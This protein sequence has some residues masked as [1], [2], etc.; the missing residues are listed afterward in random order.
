MAVNKNAL[1]RYKTID[2]C[3]QNNFRQ[4]TLNDLIEA[5][6]DALY[7]YEGKDV[8]VSKRTVQLDLQMMRSDKL[9]YNAPILVYDRKYYKYEDE[10]YSITKSPISNQDLIKL[11]EAVS[12]LKQFQGFSHFDE[13]GSM[14]QKLEDHVYTQKTH[15]K[16]LID[17]EKNDNLKGLEFLNELYQFILKKKTIE[18]TYKSFKARAENTFTFHPYLLKEF[19][20]RWFVIGKKNRNE[21]IMNLALDRIVSL[22]SSDASFVSEPNFNSETYYKNAIG[23]SVSPNLDTENVLLY[24]SHKHAPYVVTKPFHNSQKMIEKDNYG[25]TISLDVQLNFELEKEI[26][27]FGESIKV[28]AP[29]RLKRIIKER[30][31]DAVDFY[32]TEINEKSIRTVSKQLEHKGFAILSQLYSKRDIRKL[33]AKLDGY[34]K[35]NDEQPFGMREVLLKLP[36]LKSILFNKNFKKLTKAIGNNV[37]LTKAIYFDKS[38]QDN[39]YVTWHQDVPINVTRKIETEGFKSWTNKKGVIS[40]RPPEAISKNTFAMRIHLDDTNAEN[41]ALKVISGSH[42]KRLND[43]EVKLITESSIP[44]ICE[45]AL[46]GVQL[47]KPLL[48]HA[49]SKSMKQRRRRVLHLEFSSIE[50]PN[51]LKY[52]EREDL[53]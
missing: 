15:E 28:I 49:S 38:P 16:A 24:V 42:N 20:N 12:F 40:V 52:T 13:L 32:E 31:H 48:L 51:G 34:I 14:V 17:F 45:V 22:K 41:G 25:I 37:F 39:W 9:G 53:N 43:E 47:L 27:G 3:L 30:L 33:K 36:E 21:G 26:L 29:E 2:K 4:W 8:D 35:Q 11:S 44:F 1:I 10:N 5:V 50:L 7:E 23:V 6:S 46:G 18:M 19:R